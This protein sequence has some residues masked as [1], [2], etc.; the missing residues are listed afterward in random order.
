MFDRGEY[1]K[2][3]VV[4]LSLT[5]QL[6]GLYA[7]LSAIEG[8]E[9]SFIFWLFSPFAVAAALVIVYDVLVF[10]SH[11]NQDKVTEKTLSLRNSDWY[12]VVLISWFVVLILVIP[13][14][15]YKEYFRKNGH[16]A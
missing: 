9:V 10:Y 5:A 11:L 14:A 1:L 2:H 13:G 3:F 4:F 12:V 6:L 16:P 7:L 15:I 8:H